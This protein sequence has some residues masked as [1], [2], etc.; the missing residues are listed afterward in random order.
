MSLLTKG[1]GFLQRAQGKVARFA[2]T[3]GGKLAIGGAAAVGTGMG[4]AAGERLITGGA[5]DAVG[6][7]YR[8]RRGISA[9]DLRITRRTSRTIIKMYN[10]LPKRPSKSS[11]KSCDCKGACKCR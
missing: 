4:F 8:R 2:G 6:R 11:G 10:K 7:P 5:G 1:I 3:G 9:R